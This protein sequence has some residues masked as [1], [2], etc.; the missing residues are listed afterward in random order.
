MDQQLYFISTIRPGRQDFLTSM[1]PEEQRVMGEHMAY[2]KRLFDEGKIVLGGAATDGAI[3]VI[4][5]KVSS[6]EEA[7]RIFDQ[8]PA[9][10]AGIGDAELHPFRLGLIGGG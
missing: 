5:W 3:G 2:T 6:A 1:T 8:D 4:I 10:K 7:R 9:V